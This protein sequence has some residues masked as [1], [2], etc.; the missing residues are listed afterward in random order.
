MTEVSLEKTENHTRNDEKLLSHVA[1]E[2]FERDA[3]IIGNSKLQ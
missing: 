1:M 3:F 2:N